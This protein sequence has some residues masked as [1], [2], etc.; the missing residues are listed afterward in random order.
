M[1]VYDYHGQVSMMVL[2][3]GLSVIDFPVFYFLI[4]KESY[5]FRSRSVLLER[6]KGGVLGFFP[7]YKEPLAPFG[8]TPDVGGIRNR[9]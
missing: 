7:A 2:S 8:V 9:I 1:T 6:E 3:G 4:H 5:C